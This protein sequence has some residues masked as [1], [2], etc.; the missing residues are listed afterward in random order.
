MH[1]MMASAHLV[2]GKHDLVVYKHLRSIGIE[3]P[4]VTILADTCIAKSSLF[5]DAEDEDDSDRGGSDYLVT[6]SQTQAGYHQH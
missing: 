1:V 5:D 3:G 6:C 4:N 2:H